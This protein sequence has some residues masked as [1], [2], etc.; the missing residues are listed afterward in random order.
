MILFNINKW[1]GMG[2]I[3]K[4]K[5]KF[6]KNIKIEVID[7]SIH[8]KYSEIIPFLN[9]HLEKKISFLRETI[10][11]SYEYL[12]KKL[13]SIKNEFSKESHEIAQENQINLLGGTHYSTEKFACIE[14]IQF[15]AKFGLPTEFVEDEPVLEDL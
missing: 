12:E 4:I 8:L 7:D 10:K 2:I 6:K 3:S 1:C 5:N 9:S 13:L 11:I 14:M 15:F